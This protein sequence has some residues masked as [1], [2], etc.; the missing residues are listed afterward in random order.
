VPEFYGL[1]NRAGIRDD[2][3]CISMSVIDGRLYGITEKALVRLNGDGAAIAPH[4]VC[5]L[6]FPNPYSA[7]LLPSSMLTLT[8]PS[9]LPPTSLSG[10]ILPTMPLP[11]AV[12]S[13]SSS[14]PSLFTTPSTSSSSSPSSS[15]TPVLSSTSTPVAA[16][17]P[18]TISGGQLPISHPPSSSASPASSGASI[19]APSLVLSPTSASSASGVPLSNLNMINGRTISQWNEEDVVVWWTALGQQLIGYIG[20][21]HENA[22]DGSILVTLNEK[23]LADDFGVTNK[24][25]AR[26]IVQRINECKGE[27]VRHNTAIAAKTD[28]ALAAERERLRFE[29][30]TLAATSTPS[31]LSSPTGAAPTDGATGTAYPFR[32]VESSELTVKKLLASGDFGS[33]SVG[34]WRESEVVVKRPHVI[35]MSDEQVKD[36]LREASL[37]ERVCRHPHVVKFIGA[38]LGQN[39]C[40]VFEYASNGSAYHALVER[41]LFAGDFFSAF[42]ALRFP[43]TEMDPLVAL[44][45]RSC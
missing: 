21:V 5:A 38:G 16:I 32:V 14:H 19:A 22:I 29:Q 11:V 43:N 6:S 40:M 27:E 44:D 35:T 26:K 12:A 8:T 1:H 36:F 31:S 33:V 18:L 28:A 7:C 10:T 20:K 24:Y 15:P 30:L 45:H 37:C 13:S 3:N 2:W 34:E 41:K 23:E 25:H 39:V 4:A 9:T 42:A 17:A